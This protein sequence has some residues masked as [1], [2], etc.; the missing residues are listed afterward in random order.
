MGQHSREQW[1]LPEAPCS[2][3]LNPRGIKGPHSGPGACVPPSLVLTSRHT[4]TRADD[5]KEA[6]IQHRLSPHWGG[7]GKRASGKFLA[8]PSVYSHFSG[9]K[10][11]GGTNTWG[12][13]KKI[14]NIFGS[15]QGLWK[16]LG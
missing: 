13:K 8:D 4:A 16:F 3:P 10:E 12:K 15:T 2:D 11:P 14:W 6:L 7:K 9:I 5:I 1:T